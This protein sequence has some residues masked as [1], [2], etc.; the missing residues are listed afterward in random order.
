MIA[1]GSTELSKIYLGSTEVSKGY[2]GTEEIYSSGSVFSPTD[3]SGLKFWIKADSLSLS[4]NDPISTWADQSGNSNNA[5][6]SLTARPLYKTNIQ[7]SLPVARFDGSNDVMEV[8]NTAIV[9]GETGMSIF[10]VV[11]EAALTLNKVYLSK[12]DYAT[13]GCFAAQTYQGASDEIQLYFADSAGDAGVN[14]GFSLDGDLGT[15]FYLIEFI[16]N[17]TLTN[18]NRIKTYRNGTALTTG[19][20]GTI[21]TSLQSV[22]STLKIGQFGGA[23]TRNFN[24]DFGEILLYNAALS[25]GDRQL[26]ENYLIDKWGL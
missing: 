25:D 17:G 1:L 21:G 13:A 5:T 26:V 9:G 11:K 6:A 10:M 22:S 19:T 12:W 18:T 20:Q 14:Y 23:L 16:Y 24:G 15:N 4:D 2:L 3:I 7:N 8:A